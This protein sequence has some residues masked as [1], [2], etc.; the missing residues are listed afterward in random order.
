MQGKMGYRKKIYILDNELKTDNT[1]NEGG[2]AGEID[3]SVIT[4]TQAAVE[5]AKSEVEQEKT[6]NKAKKIQS[7]ECDKS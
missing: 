4:P 6:I 3:I 5:Q 2:K 7:G 1:T